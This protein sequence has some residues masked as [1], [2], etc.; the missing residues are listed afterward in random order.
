M[1]TVIYI[2]PVSQKKALCVVH[3]HQQSDSVYIQSSYYWDGW[4]LRV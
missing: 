2:A 1:D 4:L 3:E